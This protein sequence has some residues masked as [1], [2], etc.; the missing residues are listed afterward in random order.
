MKMQQGYLALLVC[1]VMATSVSATF[2]QVDDVQLEPYTYSAISN[3]LI[4][5]GMALPLAA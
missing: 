2:V 4:Q 3:N 5:S 1:L